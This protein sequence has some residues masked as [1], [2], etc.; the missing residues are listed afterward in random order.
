MTYED[1]LPILE[2]SEVLP[3]LRFFVLNLLSGFGIR[4]RASIPRDF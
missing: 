3:L 1:L 2:C 4:F